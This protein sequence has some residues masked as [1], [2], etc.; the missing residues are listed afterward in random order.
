MESERDTGVKL[1]NQGQPHTSYWNIEAAKINT[2]HPA[3]YGTD[4][5]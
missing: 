5:T 2:F 3:T 1:G 4:M